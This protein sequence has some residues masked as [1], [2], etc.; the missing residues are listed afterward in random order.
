MQY[1]I[2]MIIETDL[3]NQQNTH[4][5]SPTQ[6]PQNPR[7]VARTFGTIINADWLF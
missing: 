4:K 5:L 2:I 3:N 6:K 7:L 1:N